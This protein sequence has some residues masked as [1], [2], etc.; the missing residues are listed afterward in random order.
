MG[1]IFNNVICKFYPNN[2]RK[3]INFTKNKLK[4]RFEKVK[5]GEKKGEKKGKKNKKEVKEL[6]MPEI[7][8]EVTKPPEIET[9]KTPEI[10]TPQKNIFLL[11]IHQL[12]DYIKNKIKK[13]IK[14]MPPP[15]TFLKNFTFIFIIMFTISS[16]ETFLLIDNN[17]ILFISSFG[18][19]TG[20][21]IITPEG[22]LNQ[23]SHVLISHLLSGV[24]GATCYR[25]FGTQYSFLSVSFSVS[26][27]SGLMQ[28]FDILHF[29]AISTSVNSSYFNDITRV[30][31]LGYLFI[32]F[33][34][35]KFKK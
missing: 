16:I 24:V 18:T 17:L 7:I 9:P 25:V 6:K 4:K 31:R 27:S 2:F 34:V 3:I 33:P 19:T 11:F 15:I 20:S 10:E 1:F 26:I 14:T 23:P 12:F 30:T 32:L 22:P 21:V 13:R 28:I 8:I 35:C 5:K 29:P